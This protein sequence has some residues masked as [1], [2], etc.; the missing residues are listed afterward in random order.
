MLVRLAGCHFS[1]L[2]RSFAGRWR[3]PK[4]V[5]HLPTTISQHG[6]LRSGLPERNALVLRARE[7]PRTS[8]P[9]LLEFLC[10]GDV[11]LGNRLRNTVRNILAL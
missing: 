5:A 1:I 9:G 8:H 7:F 6:W 4:L 3:R 10:F 11:A 2:D